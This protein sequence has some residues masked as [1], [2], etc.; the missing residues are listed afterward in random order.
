[1]YKHF[2]LLL[3]AIGFFLAAYPQHQHA[4][5]G[6][7]DSSGTKMDSSRKKM[8]MDMH[9]PMDVPMS[10]SFSL[11]LPMNRNGSGTAWLPDAS[12]MYGYMIHSDKWMYMIHG[13]IAPRYDKQD[14]RDKGSRG[15]QQWDAPNWLMVMG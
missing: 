4:M 13:N 11:N 14:I 3:G 8:P 15:N 9:M 5:P 10:H 12:P 1:M 2:I 7:K 6:M